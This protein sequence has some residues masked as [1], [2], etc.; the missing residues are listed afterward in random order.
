MTHR[1]FLVSRKWL[2]LP[3]LWRSARFL[4]RLE[5]GLIAEAGRAWRD[6]MS[7][8]GAAVWAESA[9]S[10]AQRSHKQHDKVSLGIAIT[11]HIL[12]RRTGRRLSAAA[13]MPR[14]TPCPVEASRRQRMTDQAR[15]R[16][17]VTCLIQHWLGGDRDWMFARGAAVSRWR[18]LSPTPHQHRSH[19]DALTA[20][21]H[22]EGRA[23]FHGTQ[24]QP[25]REH[26]PMLTH[27]HHT[28]T[29]RSRDRRRIKYP[30][31]IVKQLLGC[32]KQPLD[33]RA[34]AADVALWRA[35]GRTDNCW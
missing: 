33:R 21:R 27:C 22:Q 20:T 13:A 1:S 23:L 11:P 12:S 31:A 5:Q 7:I 28:Y 2:T 16:F 10:L 9:S 24:M 4:Q 15:N 30:L 34:L 26:F 35:C 19:L 3:L 25:A 29:S 14:S 18:Y 32:H 17:H 8:C 6:T